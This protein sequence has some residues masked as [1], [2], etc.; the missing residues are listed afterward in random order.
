MQRPDGSAGDSRL[1][2][3]VEGHSERDADPESDQD[4]GSGKQP[5]GRRAAAPAARLPPLDAGD[6][7]HDA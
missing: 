7:A 1:W 2:V 6:R 4:G 5:A 3:V